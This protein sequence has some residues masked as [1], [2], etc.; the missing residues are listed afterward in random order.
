[1]GRKKIPNPKQAKTISL[2][3]HLWEAIDLHQKNRSYY[4]ERCL[5]VHM[6][7]VLLDE[8]E[9]IANCDTHRIATVLFSRLQEIERSYTLDH[10]EYNFLSLLKKFILERRF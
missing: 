1:M 8:S 7:D 5:K 9:H 3:K 2:P 6:N 10:E 4:I